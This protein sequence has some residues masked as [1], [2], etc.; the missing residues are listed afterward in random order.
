MSMRRASGSLRLVIALIAAVAAAIVYGRYRQDLTSARRRI[1][2]VSQVVTT[3]CGPIE[4]AV[5]GTGPPVLVVHG[6]GGGFDQGLLMAEGLIEAGYQAIAVSRFGYLRTPRPADA[7]PAAQAD[8]HSCLL[9]ALEIDRAAVLGASAGAPS[10][11]QMAIRHPERVTALI[12]LVPATFMPD[13]G[14]AGANVPPGLELIFSTAL[15]WDFPFWVASRM[16]RQTLIRTMLGTPPELLEGAGA[17]ARRHVANMLDFVLPVSDRRLGLLNE[18]EVTTALQ[19]FE[20][21][22]IRA[23]TLIISA[24]DDL[25]GTFERARYTAGEIP[26]ATFVGYPTG[27]HL[28]VGREAGTTAEMVSLLRRAQAAFL[29]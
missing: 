15:R 17:D 13:A 5:A 28:L 20:L 29:Q 18:A 4:Y 24:E 7:S 1:A 14:G 11:L 22:R 25:Y 27:G 2:S 23:P 6:A 26:G 19:R 21:E 12:L 16:A 8:A 3:P 10:S 9:D